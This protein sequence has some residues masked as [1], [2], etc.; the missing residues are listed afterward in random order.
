MHFYFLFLQQTIN[1]LKT[2]VYFKSNKQ[3]IVICDIF[4]RTLFKRNNEWE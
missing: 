1:F 3:K 4:L 2:K